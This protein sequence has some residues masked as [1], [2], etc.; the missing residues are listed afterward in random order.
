MN[1]NLRSLIEGLEEAK[2]PKQGGVYQDVLDMTWAGDVEDKFVEE[3]IK[4]LEPVV[5]TGGAA[6]DLRDLNN[7]DI[8]AENK[9]GEGGGVMGEI[10]VTVTTE[11][12]M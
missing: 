4:A 1:R 7:E 11:P 10:S 2:Q 5:M 9:G 3:T 8:N 6:K 12:K